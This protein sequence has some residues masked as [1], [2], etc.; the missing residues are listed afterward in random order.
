M[1]NGKKQSPCKRGG[2]DYGMKALKKA[3]SVLVSL[4]MIFT[5][6]LPA[7]ADEAHTVTVTVDPTLAGHTFAAYQIFSGNQD[8][9]GT[10]S[11]VQWGSGINDAGFL[12]AL[13]AADATNFGTCTTAADVAKQLS[14]MT[15]VNA[16]AKLAMAN[17]KGDSTRLTEGTNTLAVGYYLIVDT[18]EG[19]NGADAVL[20]AA[21]LQVTDTITIRAKTE[22]PSVEKKVLENTKYNQDGGYGDKYNDVADYNIGDAVPF[23]LIGTVPDMTQFTTY[24]YE[25]N[26]TLSAG[27]TAP[28]VGAVKVYVSSNKAGTDKAD[29]TG[30]AAVTVD[31]QK[32][33]VSFANL[34]AVEGVAQGKYILVEYE[35]TLN[36]RAVIGLDGNPNKVD[37]TYSNN[38]NGAGE[39]KTPEDEVIVFTYELD[40]TKV[41]G[42][43]NNTKLKGAEFKLKKIV[44]GK[45]KYAVVVNNKVTGWVDSEANGSTLTS[46]ANGLFNVIG[47]DDGTY[48]L[49]ETKAPAGYNKLTSDIE[50]TVTATTKNGQDWVD[51]DADKA[52]TKI[53]VKVAGKTADGKV[54]NG[55]V[56][57]TVENH[58][59]ATLPGT[60][61]IGTTIFYV[62]GGL[63]M[64]GAAVLLITKKRMSGDK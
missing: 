64:L 22:K 63:L 18:T 16:V 57:I 36:E 31:G 32:I 39:G 14:T 51:G 33:K 12:A 17:K 5:F 56:S 1:G 25:F 4:L 43:N 34:K 55:T 6:A 8:A 46:D 29:I 54:N 49:T 24:K 3:M 11:D 53:D 42:D 52:L 48:Y 62:V 60:G 9:D 28:A 19:T 59:G 41:D 10:L 45:D 2:K 7:F 47:L 38:P 27:L 13:K 50:L 58:K 15:D 30:N 40:V 37:L 35:A 44:D 61:G 21:L 20:N 23:K 26:D